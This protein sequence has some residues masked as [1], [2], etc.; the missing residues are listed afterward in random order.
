MNT[1]PSPTLNSIW[2]Y[3]KLILKPLLDQVFIV[4]KRPLEVNKKKVSLRSGMFISHNWDNKVWELRGINISA[5]GDAITYR[6][7]DGTAS[8]SIY[9]VAPVEWSVEGMQLSR[10][11]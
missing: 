5:N 7:D 1:H 4:C 11:Y 6:A 2:D 8:K 3:Q 9:I 10:K